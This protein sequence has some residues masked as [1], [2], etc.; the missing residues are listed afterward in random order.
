MFQEPDNTPLH[1]SQQ[2]VSHHQKS[3]AGKP[4]L[5]VCKLTFPIDS[6]HSLAGDRAMAQN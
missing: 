6:D 4:I 2:L 3:L 5:G 1:H